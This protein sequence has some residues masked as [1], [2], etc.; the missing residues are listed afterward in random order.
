MKRSHSCLE[1]LYDEEE[2]L[3]R[4][5]G[6][7]QNRISEEFSQLLSLIPREIWMTI[8]NGLSRDTDLNELRPLRRVSKWFN[9]LL[10][11]IS[12]V[13][14]VGYIKPKFFNCFRSIEILNLRGLVE[15]DLSPSS[16][17][18]R[19]LHLFNNHP[20]LPVLNNFCN[21]SNL[22]SLFMVFPYNHNHPEQILKK[23]SP[24]MKLALTCLEI[25]GGY[26]ESE[27]WLEEFPN[28]ERLIL[29]E[30]K[31][32]YPDISSLHKLKYFRCDNNM[33]IQSGYTG[34]GKCESKLGSYKRDFV[35]GR[36]HGK[37][38]STLIN[39]RSG[40]I[41]RYS[42][43]MVDGSEHGRGRVC[44]NREKVSECEYREG[45]IMKIYPSEEEERVK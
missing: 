32:T 37:G 8:L 33:M 12:E 29:L 30:G 23:F 34:Q 18:I 36:A 43:D 45:N 27:G 10:F 35:N 9:G 26:I 4:A 11:G 7:C 3:K 31:F 44:Y 25:R 15:M 24:E 17:K 40:S 22:C 42:G 16:T 21:L 6:E 39:P 19:E 20:F 5:L 13:K 28:L 41:T 38:V 2:R 14:V 1:E